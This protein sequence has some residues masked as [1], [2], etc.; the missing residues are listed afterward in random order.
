MSIFKKV[1][2]I[3]PILLLPACGSKTVYI[4]ETLPTSTTEV[5]VAATFPEAYPDV[6]DNYSTTRQ[7]FLDAVRSL[8]PTATIGIS[9]AEL[10]DF[11]ITVCDGLQSGMT[12]LDIAGVVARSSAG[13]PEVSEFLSSVTAGAIT[14]F[15]PEQLY[16]FEGY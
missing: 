8:N 10:V 11:A 12:A 5:D 15:C 7:N 13:D 3:S 2:F 4:T 6:Y 16:K 14:F 9:D 1:L